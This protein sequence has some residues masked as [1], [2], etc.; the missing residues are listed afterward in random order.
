[1][2]A[3]RDRPR[4]VTTDLAAPMLRVID[5]LVREALHDMTQSANNRIEWAHGRLKFRLRPMRNVSCLVAMIAP[6]GDLAHLSIRPRKRANAPTT[7]N[8]M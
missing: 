5:D 2:L 6:T 4:E 1:M 3:G 7:L 8:D